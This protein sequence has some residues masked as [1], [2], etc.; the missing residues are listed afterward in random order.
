M[1]MISSVCIHSSLCIL[2]ME[3]VNKL[4]D[5]D[6]L[7]DMCILM[8]SQEKG[9]GVWL[10]LT[11]QSS[12]LSFESGKYKMKNVSHFIATRTIHKR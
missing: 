3:G 9:R 1:Y 4:P 10:S 6:I 8:E 11:D 2:V 5:Y 7:E 12:A